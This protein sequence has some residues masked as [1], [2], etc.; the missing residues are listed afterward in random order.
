MT[1]AALIDAPDVAASDAAASD[2]ARKALERLLVELSSE[3]WPDRPELLERARD[4]IRQAHGGRAPRVLDPFAGGGSMPLEALRLGCDAVAL[5]LNP[6]AY[7]AL[8]A[9]LVYPQKYG[10]GE[11]Q[12]AGGKGQ[13]WRM[14]G[15]KNGRMS[16]WKNGRMGEW[17][18]G[19]M[20]EWK[21][22]RMGEWKKTSRITHHASRCPVWKPPLAPPPNSSKM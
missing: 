1:L 2:A 17:K 4:L 21:N 20:G 6:V 9:S 15:W 13:K 16:E 11:G 22:R 10:G 12:E 3:E 5:D 7:L 14:S 18:N 8:V 19:R